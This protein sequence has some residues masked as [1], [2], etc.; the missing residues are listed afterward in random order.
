[1]TI[2]DRARPGGRWEVE[3]GCALC[4]GCGGRRPVGGASGPGLGWGA[5]DTRVPFVVC[6]LVLRFACIYFCAHGS[7]TFMGSVP[8]ELLLPCARSKLPGCRRERACSPRPGGASKLVAWLCRCRCACVVHLPCIVPGRCRSPPTLAAHSRCATRYTLSYSL[9]T[10][11]RIALLLTS[12]NRRCH[13][14][15]LYQRCCSASR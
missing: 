4:G 5:V 10:R 3:T 12:P 15:S 13:L 2:D 14:L 7:H 1:M 9:A 8:C 11:C 6:L